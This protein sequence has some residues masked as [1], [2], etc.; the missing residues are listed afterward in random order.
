MEAVTIDNDPCI[1]Y[2]YSIFGFSILEKRWSCF[3]SRLM[4]YAHYSSKYYLHTYAKLMSTTRVLPHPGLWVV[5]GLLEIIAWQPRGPRFT[6]SLRCSRSYASTCR[7]SCA[8]WRRWTR[9]TR[10]LGPPSRSPGPWPEAAPPRWWTSWCRPPRRL[11]LVNWLW[12]KFMEEC[13]FW[14]TGN[15]HDLAKA[16]TI[17]KTIHTPTIFRWESQ[18]FLNVQ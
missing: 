4:S 17:I 8:A 14:K 13:L 3:S 9:R 15:S 11:A 5:T 16:S 7:S 2:R 12:A 1:S 10:S 6:S 18:F